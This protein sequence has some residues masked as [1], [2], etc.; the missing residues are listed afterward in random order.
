MADRF[1][2]GMGASSNYGL[3][4]GGLVTR[5]IVYSGPF[6][7]PFSW[8]LPVCLAYEG[9]FRGSRTYPKGIG[10]EKFERSSD[11]WP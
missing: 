3:F 4:L 11:S 1:F 9:L 2:G 10:L 8:K 6:W 7:G 5:I